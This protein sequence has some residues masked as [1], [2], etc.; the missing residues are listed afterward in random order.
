MRN[1]DDI[2][3]DDKKEKIII[4]E[5]DINLLMKEFELER[6]KASNYLA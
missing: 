4:N 5:K 2:Q 3:K 6:S 1:I